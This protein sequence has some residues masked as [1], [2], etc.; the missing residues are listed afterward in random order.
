MLRR[1]HD[2]AHFTYIHR[3]ASKESKST[4]ADLQISNNSEWSTHVCRHGVR[5]WGYH[6][7]GHPREEL[8]RFGGERRKTHKQ[9]GLCHRVWSIGGPIRGVRVLDPDLD[10]QATFGGHIFTEAWGLVSLVK[11]YKAEQMCL[12]ESRACAK[13][14]K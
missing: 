11:E 10:S 8:V 12:E 6:G 2:Y 13:S 4:H 7:P 9:I 14:Q 5:C 3:K 1:R